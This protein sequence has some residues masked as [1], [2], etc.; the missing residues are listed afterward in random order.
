[1]P[2]AYRLPA[3][4]A[5]AA[6]G[7]VLA[8]HAASGAA[9]DGGVDGAAPVEKSLSNAALP[10]PPPLTE[11]KQWVFEFRYAK[12]DV[13]L[14]SVAP[15]DA[16]APRET[17]RAMG[18]FALELYE[19]RALIERVRFDFPMLGDDLT[20]D[21]GPGF[22]AGLSRGVVT[23]IGVF[24]PATSRGRR[25]ELWDRAT[26]RRWPLSWPPGVPI[27]DAGAHVTDAAAPRGG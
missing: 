9:T 4:L 21:A 24:F 26:D 2:S 20:R 14:T 17:P 25:L 18:R 13:Q 7:A 6:A 15:F 19:G 1:M 12:G 10:D 23:R 22:G 16:G 5:L 8:G 27:A 11:R 3:A